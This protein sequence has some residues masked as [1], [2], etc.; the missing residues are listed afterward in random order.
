M[1]FLLSINNFILI[2]KLKFKFHNLINIS[3]LIFLTACQTPDLFNN[4]L[5]NEKSKNNPTYNSNDKENIAN[6]KQ[7]N[8]NL[9]PFTTMAD[10]EINNSQKT[11]IKKSQAEIL[12]QELNF[13]QQFAILIPAKADSMIINQPPINKDIN[14]TNIAILLPFKTAANTKRSR[15]LQR[16]GKSLLNSAKMALFDWRNP[17]IN[18]IPLNTFGTPQGAA[19]AAK[20]AIAKGADIILGPLLSTSVDAVSNI[21]GRSNIPIISYS[22]REEIANDNTYIM[23]FMPQQ[24]VDALVLYSIENNITKFAVMAPK[25]SY[26]KKVVKALQIATEKFGGEITRVQFYDTNATDFSQDVKII[27]DYDKRRKILLD[28][29]TELEARNDEISQAALHKIKQRE[30]L[31]DVDF[32]AILLPTQNERNLRTIAT[33]LAYYDVDQPRIKILGLQLWD[34]FNNLS[35]E[36]PLI[37]SWYATLPIKGQKNFIKRYK[38]IYKTPPDRLASLANDSMA[39]AIILAGHNGN[40][41]YSKSALTNATG[42]T[43]IEGIFR[44]KS[45][46]IAERGFAIREIRKNGNKT[47]KPAPTNFN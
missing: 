13:D 35:S 43:G 33:Q 42:F 16:L 39:L 31:G 27:S 28:K 3:L 32:E 30:T 14:G 1:T 38:N 9:P 26:G 44:L 23:G 22:N 41:D 7:K 46:G 47:I 19:Q 15:G 6:K 21:I 20:I 5:L 25:G 12:N 10:D 4:G 8:N 34:S 11:K 2:N 45:N 18:L 29:I 40:P 37:G 36:P 24:Q 17:S